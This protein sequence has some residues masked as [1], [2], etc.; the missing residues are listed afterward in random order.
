L[1]DPV[2]GE[3]RDFRDDH[4][5]LADNRILILDWVDINP[6][7][8]CPVAPTRNELT[9]GLAEPACPVSCPVDG[10]TFDRMRDM[11]DLPPR[12]RP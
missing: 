1:F 4:I 7:W 9:F 3:A 8:A 5:D 12:E 2:S 11:T 6:P 10:L